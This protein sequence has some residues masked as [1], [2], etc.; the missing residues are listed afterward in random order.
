MGQTVCITGGGSGIGRAL[1]VEAAR[2]GLDVWI[3][4]RGYD[5]LRETCALAQIPPE[6]AITADIATPEGRA[7]LTGKLPER[8]DYLVNNAGQVTVGQI[9]EQPDDAVAQ[10]IAVNLTAPI[11]L[12]RLLLPRLSASGG[13]VVNM[14]SMFGEIAFP[15]FSAYSATKFGL[16]GFSDALR[17][18]VRHQGVGVTYIAPRATQT[19]ATHAFEHLIG[20]MQMAVD[21]PEKVARQAWDGIQRGQRSI[22]PR[23]PERLFLFLQRNFPSLI[24]RAVSKQ[25]ATAL[26]SLKTSKS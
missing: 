13:R 1:A 5:A 11:A 20:P 19:G 23:G 18:E 22:V 21:P 24:D 6:H 10:M 14:G 15:F 2:R 26:Q 12:T 17:R 16:R 8:L 9:G 25:A 3:V 7:A 4:G